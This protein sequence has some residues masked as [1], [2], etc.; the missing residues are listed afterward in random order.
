MLGAPRN[1]K[2]NQGPPKQRLVSNFGLQ[3]LG[4][5]LWG[6]LAE[7][8]PVGPRPPA[9]ALRPSFPHTRGSLRHQQKVFPFVSL[10]IFILLDFMLRMRDRQTQQ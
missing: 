10:L 7:G 3:N 5:P 6:P 2:T 8:A 4:A 1:K 9:E